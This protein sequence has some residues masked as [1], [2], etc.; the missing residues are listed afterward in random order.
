[1]MREKRF[2]PNA[3][4]GSVDDKCGELD[5]VTVFFRTL[6]TEFVMPNNIAF[7]GVNGSLTFRRARVAIAILDQRHATAKCP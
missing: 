1:M 3:D 7:G 6:D 5:C 2:A 4:L